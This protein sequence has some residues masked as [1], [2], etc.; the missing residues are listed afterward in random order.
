MFTSVIP[1]LFPDLVPENTSHV[2]E[3]L[4]F[5]LHD[6]YVFSMRLGPTAKFPIIQSRHLKSIVFK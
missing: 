1:H 3:N 6:F 4:D 2:L 5:I